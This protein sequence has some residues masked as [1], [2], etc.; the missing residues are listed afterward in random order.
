VVKTWAWTA[1]S[2]PDGGGL[3]LGS[4]CYTSV[5]ELQRVVKAARPTAKVA[6][7]LDDAFFDQFK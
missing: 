1:R 5:E 6:S 4:Q 7:M 2:P 3:F